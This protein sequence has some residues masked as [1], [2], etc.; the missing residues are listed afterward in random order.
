MMIN[1]AIIIYILTM[2]FFAFGYEKTMFGL[3]QSVIL[4]ITTTPFILLFIS[5]Y[6]VSR[7]VNFVAAKLVDISFLL[8]GASFSELKFKLGPNNG[9]QNNSGDKGDE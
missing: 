4:S 8:G 7:L 3:F 2:V 1:I 5:V 9:P 6:Y